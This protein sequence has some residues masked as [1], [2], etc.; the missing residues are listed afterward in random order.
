[1]TLFGSSG[2]TSIFCGAGA[3]AGAGAAGVGSGCLAL[4]P[5]P[6]SGMPTQCQTPVLLRV[7]P[8]RSTPP[9]VASGALLVPGLTVQELA[10]HLLDLGQ[11]AHDRFELGIWQTAVTG[12]HW[13][14]RPVLD[15]LVPL[16]LPER[17]LL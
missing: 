5:D 15:C 7:T 6:C 14:G 1:M 11:L 16:A 13:R 8:H 10:E 2:M 17:T 4:S 3:C 9:A 12:R